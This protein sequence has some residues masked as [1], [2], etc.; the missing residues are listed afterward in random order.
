M[1]FGHFLYE[2]TV[3]NFILIAC[4]NIFH[5]CVLD[6]SII[7][8]FHILFYIFRD[9]EYLRLMKYFNYV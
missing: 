9:S 7:V 4:I 6:D 3:E 2:I 8:I 5:F 1:Y